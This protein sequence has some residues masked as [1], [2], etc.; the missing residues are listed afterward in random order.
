[1]GTSEVLAFRSTWRTAR[2]SSQ[3]VP[4]GVGVARV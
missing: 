1:M 4:T 2:F 3:D